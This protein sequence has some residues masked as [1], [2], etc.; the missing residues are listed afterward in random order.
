MKG[1][2]RIAKQE[3]K[4]TQEHQ[5]CFKEESNLETFHLCIELLTEKVNHTSNSRIL[6][7]P[8][9]FFEEALPVVVGPTVGG[10]DFCLHWRLAL[11]T[12]EA[13]QQQKE[14]KLE[15][16][17]RYGQGSITIQNMDNRNTHFHLCL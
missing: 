9:S 15:C 7:L 6:S 8:T 4:E 2:S 11:I 17:E 14:I 3:V 13:A 12:E 10:Q 1:L 16:G 5:T